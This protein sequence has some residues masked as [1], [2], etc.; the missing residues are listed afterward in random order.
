MPDRCRSWLT[1]LVAAVMAS[2]GLAGCA[3]VPDNGPAV[4]VA[5]PGLDQS[6]EPEDSHVNAVLPHPEE[7]AD[8]HVSVAA[9]LNALQ[10]TR[11]PGQLDV[12]LSNSVRPTFDQSPQVVIVKDIRTTVGG[13]VGANTT[14][15]FTG[16]LVGALDAEGVFDDGGGRAWQAQVRMVRVRGIW[17]FADP[18]PLI[19]DETQFNDDFTAL[20]VYFSAKPSAVTGTDPELVIPERRYVNSDL[21][22]STPTQVVDFVL[23][24]PS[25]AL[26]R[27]ARNPLPKIK[28]TSRVSVTGGDLVIEL[29]P[30]AESASVDALNDFVAEV[31]WSLTDRFSGR[32]K[33]LV[34]GRPLDVAGFT[35][36][37][38]PSMWKRYN[39]STLDDLLPNYLV[40][41][42]AVKRTA[43]IPGVQRRG[44]RLESSTVTK[45]V[46]T[47][48]IS[49]DLN[50][51]AVV[52]N[53]PA[54][55]QRL[56]IADA[57]GTLQPTLRAPVIGRPSWGGSSSTVVVP[58]GGKLFQVG[59][60]NADHPTQVEVFGDGK[61]LLDIT[62]VRLSLDETRALVIAG[63][64]ANSRLYFGT[65]TGTGSGGALI[66]TSRQLAV[67]GSP[68]DISW[69][70]PVTAAVAVVVPVSN[71]VSVALVPIDGAPD[72]VQTTSK[73]DAN[74][75][76]LAADPSTA[77][78]GG[79]PIQIGDRLYRLA[80]SGPLEPQASAGGE[81]PFFPG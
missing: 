23:A 32:V 22:P 50:R 80:I 49:F 35:A 28:R 52:R 45:G 1:L 43:D 60:G 78:Q 59:V 7:G 5:V 16:R 62:T 42:G 72:R 17:V 34:G 12:F 67:D 61:R 58:V 13:V 75:I 74:P 2:T 8:P 47:A 9:Y 10:G 48:A 21:T 76:R 73:P 29:E 66:M 69:W 55:G 57:S 64:G 26:S 53:D 39:P 19:L 14:A 20:N 38:P 40:Q 70:G 56:W 36:S 41:K 6:S 63:S 25:D 18:P 77:Q 30:E 51:L 54:G 3:K 65:L 15:L 4:P 44:P 71:G 81:A 31:G 27:V 79:L 46:H 24:G 11:N 37:Q 68:R 33:L